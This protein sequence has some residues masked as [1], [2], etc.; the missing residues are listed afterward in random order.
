MDRYKKA[1]A[2][3]AIRIGR[4]EALWL[5]GRYLKVT[6]KRN[7]VLVINDLKGNGAEIFNY[8]SDRF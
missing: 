1:Y 5:Q 7:I 3:S 6:D 2:L 8:I 4:I